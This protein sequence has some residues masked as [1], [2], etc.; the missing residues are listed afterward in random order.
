MPV[1]FDMLSLL[2]HLAFRVFE[3][4]LLSPLHYPNSTPRQKN[5]TKVT[6]G[7]FDNAWKAADGFGQEAGKHIGTAAAEA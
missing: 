5:H 6:M 2:T 3:I 1:Q 7:W 4:L